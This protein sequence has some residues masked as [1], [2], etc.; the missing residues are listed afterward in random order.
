MPKLLGL[1][2][3]F[4]VLAA[5]LAGAVLGLLGVSGLIQVL[6]VIV[7]YIAGSVIAAELLK[8]R[9]PGAEHAGEPDEAKPRFH[10]FDSRALERL[11]EERRESG[12]RET[13]T[14]E[15]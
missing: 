1:H 2:T 5:V 3:L 4:G 9:H 11:E 10:H 6:F 15:D 12:R 14:P 7:A 8:K 13:G